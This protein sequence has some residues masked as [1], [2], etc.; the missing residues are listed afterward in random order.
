MTFTATRRTKDGFAYR[1]NNSQCECY[2]QWASVREGSKISEFTISLKTI[3]KVVYFIAKGR[4]N[5]NILED[6]EICRSSPSEIK[7]L[8]N[9]QI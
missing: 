9:L 8:L 7:K 2:R 4:L 5:K 3:L 6:C 1:Y